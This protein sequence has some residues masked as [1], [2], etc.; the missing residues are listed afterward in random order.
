[1]LI[2]AVS[3]FV[4]FTLRTIVSIICETILLLSSQHSA[5]ETSVGQFVVPWVIMSRRETLYGQVQ[6]PWTDAEPSGTT[7]TNSKVV[8][9]LGEWHQCA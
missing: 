9:V 5:V 4:I 6:T 8:F 2:T 7:S 1:M 3:A